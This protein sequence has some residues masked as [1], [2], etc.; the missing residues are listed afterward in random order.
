MIFDEYKARVWAIEASAKDKL[1][2]HRDETLPV[3]KCCV[4]STNKH[5]K[6]SVFK[7][8]VESVRDMLQRPENLYIMLLTTTVSNKVARE[9][10]L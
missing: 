8:A 3:V 9:M 5:Y 1:A 4:D 10:I 2:R 6:Q 7:H